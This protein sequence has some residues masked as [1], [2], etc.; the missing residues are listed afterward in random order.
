MLSDIDYNALIETA[1]TAIEDAVDASDL[2]LDCETGIGMLTID[3]GSG[4]PLIFSRQSPTRELW[5]AARS[6]GY[7]FAWREGGWVC[8]RSGRS[9]QDVFAQVTEEQAGTS[10]PLTL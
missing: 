3:C 8:T 2:D 7:H 10:I 9:L 6:G 5:L 4:G 1:F